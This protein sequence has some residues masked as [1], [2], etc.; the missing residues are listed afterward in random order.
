MSYVTISDLGELGVIHDLPPHRLPENAWSGG[1]NARF[2]DGYCAR[3]FGDVIVKNPPA[4]APF[5]L[6]P[7][8]GAVP[9]WGYTNLKKW[10]AVAGGAHS[11]VTRTTGGDYTGTRFD[12][13]NGDWLNGVMILTNGVDLPQGWNPIAPTTPLVNLVNWP[14]DNRAKI[15]RSIKNY[16]VAL[17]VTK[18]VTEFPTLVKWSDVTLPGQL[19]PSWDATDPTTQAGE[20]PVSGTPGPIVDGLKMRESLI[21]YKLGSMTSMTWVGG[22]DIF[23]WDTVSNGTGALSLGCAAQLPT[24]EH[25]VLTDEL[26]VIIH[27][28]RDIR[29]ILDKKYR[30]FLQ[31]EINPAFKLTSFVV[32]DYFLKHAIVCFP[33]GGSEFPNKAII[34]DW[35]NN[36]WG[37]RDLIP[38]YDAKSGFDSSDDLLIELAWSDGEVFAWDDDVPLIL[39]TTA[40]LR[41][42]Q[43]AMFPDYQ[44]TKLYLYGNKTE[45]IGGAAFTLKLERRGLAYSGRDRRGALIVDFSRN[46]RVTAIRPKVKATQSTTVNLFLA[47]YDK[48][49]LK[50]VEIPWIGPIPFD[51]TVDTLLDGFLLSGRFFAIRFEHSDSAADIEIHGYD[52]EVSATGVGP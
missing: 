21:V 29:S 43:G 6:M 3:A 32:L 34:W 52:I 42:G 15:F 45:T 10:Y 27:N 20:Y 5:Y 30:R 28:G 26:D 49:D 19:P 9:V 39:A 23:R 33:T 18:D 46:K 47:A 50:S 44:N 12:K 31:K 38:C 11:D 24:G 13:W 48:E 36:T 25:F 8:Y 40:V 1:I 17:N 37:C 2:Q 51:P 14:S 41:P 4:V 35:T 22:N 16:F 7:G